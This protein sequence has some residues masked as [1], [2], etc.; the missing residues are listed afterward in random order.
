MKE[1]HVLLG[2]DSYTVYFDSGLLGRVPEILDT[3][4]PYDRITVV[5]DS[6]VFPLYGDKLCRAIGIP[7]ENAFV[8]EAGE[9]SKTGETVMSMY[10]HFG[11]QKLTRSSIVL[12]LGGGVV[13]DLC[14]FAAATYMRGIRYIQ[15]PTTLL[16]MTDSSIGGKT[17]FDLPFGKNLVGAFHQ[18]QAVIG[19]FDVLSTVKPQFITDGMAEVIKY[20]MICD[21]SMFSS[22]AED[23]QI[24]MKD[25]IVRCAEI[26]ASV[27]SADARE[28]GIRKILNFGH[29]IG[30]ALE[31][32]SDF[33]GI[34]HGCA[35]AVGMMAA[36]CFGEATG[37]T[38]SGTS[39]K[40]LAVLNRFGLPSKSSENA[41]N[42]ISCLHA[43]K[44]CN[45][46]T[47]DFI[48]CSEIGKAKVFPTE[49]ERIAEFV[50]NFFR[51]E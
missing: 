14:G 47:I 40:L 38:A 22:L 49:L 35:V 27:V 32:C 31:K 15:I 34:T 3:V 48:L 2:T 13:G 42:I 20:A 25:I 29:T 50:R 12:A 8:F 30:H 39:E 26:K 17:G 21:A 24:S 6:N 37:Q 5:S 11:R 46:D 44:K 7:P 41:E 4:K 43:D 16:A 23:P 9:T 51:T 36:V 10:E 19:D 45:R 33:S 1:V 18:P 28:N